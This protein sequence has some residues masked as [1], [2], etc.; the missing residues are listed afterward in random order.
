MDNYPPAR[1]SKNDPEVP[2]NGLPLLP[3]SNELETRAVLKSAIDARTAI[4]DLNGISQRLPNP[5]MLGRVLVLQEAKLS[6]EIENIVTT[7]DAL[8]Q[9]ENRKTTDVDPAVKEVIQYSNAVWEG[10]SHLDRQGQ[11][12]LDLYKRLAS[13]IN[14]EPTE[15]RDVP[16]TYIGNRQ[17]GTIAYTPPVGAAL[18]N[19]LLDN[20]SDFY[21]MKDDLDPLVKMA[22]AHYQ[23]EAIHPFQDGNGR[24]GRVLNV[25]WLVQQKLISAPILYLSKGIL[26]DKASYYRGLRRVTENGD[27]ENWLLYILQI[28]K[29]SAK[30]TQTL[31]EAVSSE[32]QNCVHRVQTELPKIYSRELVDLLFSQ[33]YIRISALEEE[34]IAKRQTASQY[35]KALANIGILE[36]HR[37]GRDSLFLNK[38]LMDILNA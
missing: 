26:E 24:A 38:P 27:W 8:Y 30:H 29:H 32:H 35:L 33:P 1:K 18:I 22:V 7:N 23:F 12:E 20:L 6:S 36:E 11:F 19:T 15:V 25:L 17:R 10:I 14:Q 9:S 13:T 21:Q 5:S 4:S 16:G 28:T 3:P 37:V 31:L 2:Y 34:G